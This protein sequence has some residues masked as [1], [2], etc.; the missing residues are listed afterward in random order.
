LEEIEHNG[1]HGRFDKL[2]TVERGGDFLEWQQKLTGL[3][4]HVNRNNLGL[5]WVCQTLCDGLNHPIAMR[6]VIF[7]RLSDPDKIKIGLRDGLFA[8]E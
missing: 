5:G 8:I 1:D 3:Q 7:R 4:I 6:G 2:L